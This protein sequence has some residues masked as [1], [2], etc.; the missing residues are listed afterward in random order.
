MQFREYFYSILNRTISDIREESERSLI[1]N[2][3]VSFSCQ[4]KNN[5][6]SQIIWCA[7]NGH[8]DRAA[9]LNG[10]LNNS[11]KIERECKKI[12]SRDFIDLNRMSFIALFSIIEASLED[13][14]S[15]LIKN[16]GGMDRVIN[17]GL[18]PDSPKNRELAAE[19][20]YDKARKNSKKSF[21]EFHVDISRAFGVDLTIYEEW[22]DVVNEMKE[23][24]NCFLHRAG[25]VDVKL[26]A[27]SA[28]WASKEG[29]KIKIDMP[30]YYYFIDKITAFLKDLVYSFS[31]N[32][33]KQVFD[34]IGFLEEG[35]G[36]LKD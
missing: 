35:Y 5:L 29:E 24:R 2:C 32:L 11:D 31:R 13:A 15:M 9:V 21:S 17:S 16:E 10:L 33:E 8:K 30:L 1:L 18:L 20:A 25:E 3:V 14:F 12:A 19:K 23:I 6:M 26:A 7:K 36:K 28:R 22:G 27:I 34:E 4:Q